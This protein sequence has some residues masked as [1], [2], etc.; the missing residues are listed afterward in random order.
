[1]EKEVNVASAAPGWAGPEVEALRASSHTGN[2]WNVCPR[3]SCKSSV[4]EDFRLKE[5]F[6]KSNENHRLLSLFGKK[7]PILCIYSCL[8]A[9][10]HNFAWIVGH[11]LVLQISYS[12]CTQMPYVW[13]GARHLPS[14]TIP[15]SPDRSLPSQPPLEVTQGFL[16]TQQEDPFLLGLFSLACPFCSIIT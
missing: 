11:I 12:Q 6:E 5:P 1:M 9:Q 8:C 13:S 10:T 4:P 14:Q 15:E 2:T 16:N 3:K 7:W